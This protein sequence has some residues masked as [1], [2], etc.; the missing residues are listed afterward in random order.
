MLNKEELIKNISYNQ[1]TGI[2]LKNGINVG[3]S[4][5]DG[6][7]VIK[8]KDKN[9]KAHRLA[10][11]Y[12]TGNFPENTVDH[13]NG[14]KNDNRWINLRKATMSENKQNIK[15]PQRN[16]TTGYLGVSYHKKIGKF[17]AGIKINGIAKHLGYFE[18]A[19]DAYNIYL[20]YKRNIH[21]FCTL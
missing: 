14:I 15:A 17:R 4:D 11:L 18:N 3:C 20:A 13:I 7:L 9:Y 21:K 12:I 5:K 8:V 2:F 16:N 19:K 6:Y 1:E 10:F